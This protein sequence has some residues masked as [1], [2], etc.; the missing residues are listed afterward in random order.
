[1]IA[2]PNKKIEFA[3]T[4]IGEFTGRGF[5]VMSKRDT[6]LLVF[7]LLSEYAGLDTKSNHELSL[8]FKITPTKVKNYRFDRR[9][10]FNQLSEDQIKKTFIDGLKKSSIKINKALKWI[11]LSIE[12]SYVREAIK[13]KLKAINHFSDSS[14][15]NE[16]MTLDTEAFSDLMSAFYA[17]AVVDKKQLKGLNEHALK[18]AKDKSGNITMKGLIKAFMEGAAK[19]GGKRTIGAGLSF[20]TGGVSDVSIIISRIKEYFP[21]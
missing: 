7:H 15:N 19:E 12:D 17:D 14:F 6:E 1:M 16:L 11:V 3:E 2:D 8:L 21:K 5:G 10:R 20:L 4:F 9:L 13:A 18:I